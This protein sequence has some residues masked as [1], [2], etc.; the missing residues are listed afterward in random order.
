[1]SRHAWRC[2][3]IGVRSPEQ[4][5]R[6]AMDLPSVVVLVVFAVTAVV[7][8]AGTAIIFRSFKAS[9]VPASGPADVGH[10]AADAHA[11]AF[12]HDRTTNDLLKRF[13]DGKACAIC[14]RPI[15]PVQRT[16]MKPG[17]LNPDSHETHSWDQIPNENLPAM[18]QNHLAVCFDCQLAQSFRQRFPDLV[19]DRKRSPQ[20][21]PHA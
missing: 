10:H 5:G 17:L 4:Q 20:D 11:P 12:H 16:G 2:G 19:V 18:L 9:A 6:P 7:L 14:K 15:A 8:W 13:F 1:M 21:T 3:G